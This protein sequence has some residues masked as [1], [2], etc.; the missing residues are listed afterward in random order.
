[1][2]ESDSQDRSLVEDPA[3]ASVRQL[4]AAVRSRQLSSRELLEF[5]LARVERLDGALNLV[6]TIDAER[7]RREADAADEAVAQGQPLGPLHGVPM[8]VKD[9]FS[10]AG[11]RT[12]SG[13]PEL[14]DH[15]PDEDADPVR[16][17]RE[18]GAVIWGKTNLPLYAGDVQ[19]YNKVFGRSNNPWEP[20]RTVGGSSGGSA[21]ALA[22]GFTALELGSDI[23][24]SIRNPSHTCG[25]LGHK[26]SYGVVS[27]RGQI[28]GPP[29]TLTQADIAVAGPLARTVGDLELGL[30]LLAGADAW[31]QVGWK[32]DLPAPRHKDLGA[33]RI[34]VWLEDA[35]CPLESEVLGLLMRA[36]ET[37]GDAGAKLSFTA[38]PDFEFA[39]ASRVFD[40][41]LGAAL[42]GQY[43]HQKIEEMAAK[44]KEAASGGLAVA[45]AV[46]RHRAWLSANERRLQMRKKWRAFFQEWDVVLLP[47]SPVPAILH[48]DSEPQSQRTILI[49]GVSRPYSEQIK[50][51]GLT[52][53][54]YLPA[55]VVPVGTTSAGLPVGIQIAGPY[56]EDHTTLQLARHLCELIGGFQPPPGF[57]D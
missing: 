47:V 29:G 51:M 31:Q 44:P 10:T 17:L 40:Q 32:L 28:P 56:L 54:A 24:G 26:P 16:R 19:S 35:F 39:Y 3:Y 22:A 41:L 38:R 21:G 12:T 6:V 9:S 34:A 2:P 18:A 48:D 43:S 33:F 20:S 4:A 53:V 15:I 23:G 37:L 50:W 45:N 42:C 46:L 36:A 11:M 30:D 55:T 49:D 13:A 8:T 1:M 57:Q 7:A 27:A 5:Y 25:V 14:V 52:G